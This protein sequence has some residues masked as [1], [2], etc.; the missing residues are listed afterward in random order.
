SSPERVERRA[1]N[2]ERQKNARR[3]TFD[4]RPTG[5]CGEVQMPFTAEEIQ[6]NREFFAD[7]LRAM[8][9]KTDVEHW[10]KGEGAHDFL[11]VDVRGRDPFAKAHVQGAVCVPIQEIEQLA[12]QLPKDKPLVLY[13]WSHF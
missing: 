1:S 2:V 9:Q 13:C 8:E 6:A 7:K 11:L 4:A 12:P 5:E 3:W 10:V